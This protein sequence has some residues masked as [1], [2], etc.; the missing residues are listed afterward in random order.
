MKASCICITSGE[1][2]RKSARV[3]SLHREL[4]TAIRISFQRPRSIVFLS[5]QNEVIGI[6]FGVRYG[7]NY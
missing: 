4:E 2:K 3:G 6:V 1:K 7:D 5:A